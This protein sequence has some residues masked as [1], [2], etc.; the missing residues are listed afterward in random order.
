M[1][2]S[3]ITNLPA[4][5][6]GASTDEFVIEKAGAS[7]KL[8]LAQIGSAIFLF[9]D[10][11]WR[12]AT[13]SVTGFQVRD[14]AGAVIVNI[15]T[16]NG[17]M[18]IGT[19]TPLFAFHVSST[20][21]IIQRI[22]RSSGTVASYDFQIGDIGAGAAQLFIDAVTNDTGFAFRPKSSGGSLSTGLFLDPDGNAG[23]GT[24]APGRILEISDNNAVIRIAD[25]DATTA[26]L[27]TSFLEFG[28][29][30][31]GWERFVFLGLGS[32]SND[33]F[34]VKNES[35]GGHILV[36]ATGAGAVGIGP[37]NTTPTGTLHVQNVAGDT[38]AIIK[39]GAVQT[40]DL[41]SWKDA[42]DV[43]LASIGPT[44]TASAQPGGSVP[45]T[46]T[47]TVAA[48]ALTT[49]AN[50]EDE[51]LF[52]LPARSKI[53]SISVKASTAFAGGALSAMTVSIGD[54]SGVAF[55]TLAF[56]IF[57][58]VSDTN[59]QDTDMYKS[60]TF[61]AR[62]VLARFTSTGDTMD[63]VTAGDVEITVQ[64]VTLPS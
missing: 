29:N 33:D 38:S 58:A 4:A 62:D 26:D 53:L 35:P 5:S 10:V 45:V 56:D 40:A 16:I 17:R 18:G 51:V 3:R 59:F 37:G 49:A 39:A 61:A 14:A 55:Y 64:W 19:A 36:T 30:G 32:S 25:A 52:N 41:Q 7:E 27:T 12:N 28:K 13:D 46:K 15:D 48:A 24:T 60:S 31:G 42:S 57:A 34:S 1:A 43:L 20:D 6:A 54:S 11:V 50:T 21:A 63:N 2:D 22:T 8:T 44:G 9:D 47:Y 23:I